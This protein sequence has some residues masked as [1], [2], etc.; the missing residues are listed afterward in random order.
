LNKKKFPLIRGRKRW[1]KSKCDSN[2]VE[3]EGIGSNQTKDKSAAN[4]GRPKTFH[5][6]C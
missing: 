2:F 5:G 4:D 3:I 1:L 6:D